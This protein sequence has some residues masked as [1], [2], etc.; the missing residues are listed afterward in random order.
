MELIVQKKYAWPVYSAFAYTP[1]S[2]L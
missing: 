2:F 1:Y